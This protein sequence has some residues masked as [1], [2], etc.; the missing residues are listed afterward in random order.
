MGI[1]S[2]A[3]IIIGAIIALIFGI[4]ILIIAFKESL[5]WGIGSLLIPFVGL[6]FVITHWD[7]TKKPFLCSLIAIPFYILGG[8]LAPTPEL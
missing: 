2:F 3:L 6:I 7:A 4:Q 8:A 5:L 1:I